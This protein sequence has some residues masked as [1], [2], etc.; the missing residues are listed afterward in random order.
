MDAR[1]FLSQYL[2]L[3]K[4]IKQK[5]EKATEIRAI[6]E[7]T[8]ASFSSF[9]SAGTVS[10]KV[11]NGAVVLAD[12]AKEMEEESRELEKTLKKIETVIET[13]ES[14]NQK[15]VLRY[16]YISGYSLERIAVELNYSWRQIRRYHKKALMT[17]DQRF[18]EV[19]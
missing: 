14:Q 1:E 2:K 17:I 10:D 3:E 4:S 7:K 18:K 16:K 8:T 11:G 9:S 13:L 6:A 15:N 5:Q 12:L 19:L